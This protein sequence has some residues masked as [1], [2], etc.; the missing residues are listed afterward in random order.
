MRDHPAHNVPL[1]GASWGARL[2]QV[3]LMSLGSVNY[4][5][6][7]T[8]KADCPIYPHPQ[9]NIREKWRRSW[10]KMLADPL[11]WAPTTAKGPDQERNIDV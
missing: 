1:L 6:D 8:P 2:S 9:P 3:M 5:A 11:C 7:P 4:L 10:Q